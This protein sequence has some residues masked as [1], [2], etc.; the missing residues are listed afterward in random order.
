[1]TRK[2]RNIGI[3]SHVDAGKTTISEHL[4]FLGG[5]IKK[6]GDVNH[7]TTVSDN[8]KVEKERGV[9]V[10]SSDMSFLWNDYLINLIDTPGHTDFSAEVERSLQ[11]MDGAI[12]VI[13]A[14]EGLQAHTYALWQALNTRNIPVLFFINKI[15]RQGA[16]F[17][18]VVRAIE[19]EFHIPV[20]LMYCPRNEGTNLAEIQNVCVSNNIPEVASFYEYSMENLAELDEELLEV[21]LE[22]MRISTQTIRAKIKFF[23]QSNQLFP[24][25]CGVAKS[26]IG[27]TELLDA[28]IEF[29]PNPGESSGKLSALVYKI[30][31][32]QTMGRLAHV[33]VFDGEIRVRDLI[34]NQKSGQQEKIAQ[35]KKSLT[36][37]LKDMVAL[38][39][40][41]I[42]I[43]SGLANANSGDILGSDHKI[44]ARAN[45]QVPMMTVQVIPENE[46]DF[47]QLAQALETLYLEDPK[48]NMRWYRNEKELH[49][50][51]MGKIQMEILES[52]ILQRFGLPVRFGQPTIIY[53]E[54][55][56][57][58]GIGHASYTMPK[59]C[60]AVC[61]FAIEPAER[62]SGISYESRVSVDK[63]KQK[64]QN[65]IKTCIQSAL[66]QGIKGWEVTDAI[67]TLIDGEDHE[68]HSRPG[69]FIIATPMALMN[70]L[71]KIGTTLLEPML[72]FTIVAPEELLGK[73]AG[74][75]HKMRGT[76]DS[77]SFE[78][79]NFELKGKVPA[80]TSLDYG[81]KLG[82]MS[83]GKGQ[84]RFSF[85]GYEAC[86]DNE[87][88]IRAYKGVNPLDRS[89]W[90]LHAR[91]AFKSDERRM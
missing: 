36:G 8:L 71:L 89:K 44:P 22:G 74:D 31:H 28:I 17:E 2:I 50:D 73:V 9:S 5:A 12:L 11:I 21:W 30:E 56:S 55:P 65:E 39:S 77:P 49:I 85:H 60:W 37:K 54:T 62:G 43:V 80:A 41:D 79:G 88:M 38:E 91:G 40:G 33:R 48:L 61:T 42:G 53:K 64:Y 13:S 19:K 51:L 16:N 26:G 58:K 69:D 52:M 6:P 63:I 66:A 81:I 70:G 10:R 27:I 34:L 83:S 25:Y 82:S 4:L 7:G 78:N 76:F 45:V 18:N 32:D 75:L 72:S 14:V 29:F 57:G 15:D 20:F 68:I 24:V 1:M 23:T 67:I 90:I 3:L 46:E 35:I 59:P 84:A 87:G 47:V 86:G